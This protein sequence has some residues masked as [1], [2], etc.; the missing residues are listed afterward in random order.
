MQTNRCD[1]VQQ[2]TFKAIKIPNYDTI[3]TDRPIQ[4]GLESTGITIQVAREN[5]NLYS[6]YLSPGEDFP[7]EG[8]MK[9]LNN[10]KTLI[11]EQHNDKHE[12][13]EII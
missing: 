6:V 2:N 3:S 9:M 4:Q 1:D 8:I 10:R 13:K 5:V 12:R 11:I 7:R